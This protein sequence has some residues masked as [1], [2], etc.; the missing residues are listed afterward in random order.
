MVFHV[1]LCAF[2][3]KVDIYSFIDCVCFLTPISALVFG[4]EF[5]VLHFQRSLVRATEYV[6]SQ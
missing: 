4:S 3:V 2:A 5:P 6:L 1:L